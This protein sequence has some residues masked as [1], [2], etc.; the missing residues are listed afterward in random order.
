MIRKLHVACCCLFILMEGVLPVAA[1]NHATALPYSPSTPLTLSRCIDIALEHNRKRHISKLAVETAEYQHKQALSA[2]WPQLTASSAYQQL[3]EDVNFIFPSNTYSYN[4]AVPGLGTLAGQTVVPEQDVTVADR[5]SIISSLN[6]TYPLF[7]GGLR[8]NAAKAAKSNI[9]AARQALRRTELELVR[10]VQR[11]YYG[12]VLASRLAD[13]GGLQIREMDR[14][15]RKGL[16]C[17]AGGSRMF[18]EEKIGKR[19]NLERVEEVAATKAE[20]LVAA[21]PFCNTM[22]NDGVKETASPV[23]VKD[24]AEILDQATG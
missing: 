1:D 5:Q 18:M 7:T 6:M 14:S 17:G 24:I 9:Q 16:C 11:M 15:G 12:A 13:I 22:L 10:D 8:S 4:V 21:C 2:F 20:T 19:I 23:A 3:D